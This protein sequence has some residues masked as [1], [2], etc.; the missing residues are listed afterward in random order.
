VK[1]YA[2]V[3]ALDADRD[4]AAIFDFL[5][6]SYEAFG[7]DA[8]TAFDRAADRVRGIEKAMADLG[9]PP[10]QGTLRPDHLPG[11]RTITKNGAVFYFD[12]DDKRRLVRILA[13]FFGGQDH[14]RHMLKRL[15]A[16]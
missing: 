2:V 4:L 15:L 13:V 6:D 7:D 12:I 3:R 9:A 14:R 16:R 8:D 11:L 10:H 1:K 5:I